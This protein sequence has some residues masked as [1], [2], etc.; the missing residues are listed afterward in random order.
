[1]NHLLVGCVF[2]REMWFKILRYFGLHDLTPQ[3]ELPF[4]DWWLGTRKRVYKLQRKGFNSL[5]LLVAWSLWKERNRWVHERCAL[6][7]VALAPLILEEAR[8]WSHTGF[9]EIR[10][11]GRLRL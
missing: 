1:M 2:A 7:P 5:V 10:S 8:M 3:V 4:F 11:L 9:A 6:Q